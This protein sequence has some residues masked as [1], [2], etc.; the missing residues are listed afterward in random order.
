MQYFSDHT[1]IVTTGTPV[2]PHL[3]VSENSTQGKADA[4]FLQP[5]GQ[6]Y[7]KSH[8]SYYKDAN[9]K[10][11]YNKKYIFWRCKNQRDKGV[12]CPARMRTPYNYREAST[13]TYFMYKG[14]AIGKNAGPFGGHCENC[15]FQVGKMH[16]DKLIKA[17]KEEGIANPTKMARDILNEKKREMVL[18][19]V[20]T[21]WFPSD[22][23]MIKLIDA[24]RQKDRI[25]PPR[26]VEDLLTHVVEV[27]AEGFENFYRGDV[28]V[29]VGKKKNRHF[30]FMTD[31]QLRKLQN[32]PEWRIDGTFK[33]V[34][35]PHYQLLSIHAIDYTVDMKEVSIPLCFVV[36]SGKSQKDYTA[37]FKELKKLL[38]GK[39][40]INLKEVLIDFEVAVWK[41]LT[42]VFGNLKEDKKLKIRGCWF[43]FCQAIYRKVKEFH[44]ENDFLNCENTGSS[45]IHTMVKMLMAMALL[46]P[47]NIP[48]IFDH[49]KKDYSTS[50][51]ANTNIKKLF[52]YYEK[53]WITGYIG[54]A[55]WSCWNYE[56]RT[57]NQL[58]SWNKQIWMDGNQKKH[59]LY[60]IGKVLLN[61]ATRMIDDLHYAK[62]IYLDKK[63]LAK[64]T[65]IKGILKQYKE[66]PKKK[67]VALRALAHAIGKDVCY[68]S[69]VPEWER[70]Q[71]LDELE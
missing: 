71:Q 19:G 47:N 54:P 3:E 56:C 64:D 32:A 20:P 69:V 57:N 14:T 66:E 24:A 44:L 33:I 39:E 7:Q 8:E 52:D 48:M 23:D 4:I 55:K 29:S 38:G 51:A 60:S 28:I 58:E 37:V 40:Q 63:Q 25:R 12:N 42:E 49:M 59:D 46:E 30:F 70:H 17:C 15:K 1:V 31:N 9:G 16:K 2:V 45:Q 6:E 41:S 65:N 22:K 36:M 27:N 35:T 62:S 50:I 53:Q 67:Y 5:M 34:L 21:Q 61:N 11:I 13:D 10:R 68:T 18:K 26:N 43:H